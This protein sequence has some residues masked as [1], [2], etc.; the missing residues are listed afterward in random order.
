MGH[1]RS[2]EIQRVSYQVASRQHL[3]EALAAL[4]GLPQLK[5]LELIVKNFTLCSDQLR[6]VGES[7]VQRRWLEGV[8]DERC[9]P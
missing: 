7:R 3:D 4:A 6:V 8:K 5:N 2:P 1:S 9:Y